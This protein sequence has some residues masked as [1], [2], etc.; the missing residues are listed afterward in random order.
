VLPT[1]PYSD[2]GGGEGL[3]AGMAA[4]KWQD[5]VPKNSCAGSLEI[6]DYGATL[7]LLSGFSNIYAHG[8][9]SIKIIG[10]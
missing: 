7:G 10:T 3:R 8:R 4:N 9:S 5:I 2:Q 1:R 6:A